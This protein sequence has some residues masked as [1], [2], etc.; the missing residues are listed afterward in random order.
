MIEAVCD[1][2]LWIY[3]FRALLEREESKDSLV[4]LVSRWVCLSQTIILNYL[5]L[6]HLCVNA[7]I[8]LIMAVSVL[9]VVLLFLQCKS[10]KKILISQFI[11]LTE[12][13]KDRFRL[14]WLKH[15][16]TMTVTYF[17]F[18]STKMCR[19]VAIHE[20]VVG[21]LFISDSDLFLLTPFLFLSCAQ[22]L[23]GPPGPPGEGGKPGDQVSALFWWNRAFKVA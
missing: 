3:L 9:I 15:S 20:F 21:I 23:P 22:G 14:T 2:G 1:Y 18:K 6:L 4:P 12:L 17:F 7:D 5:K 10:Y 13:C 19:F 16:C 8:S 11:S